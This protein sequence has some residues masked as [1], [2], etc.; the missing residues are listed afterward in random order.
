MDGDTKF[1]PING[2]GAEDYFCGS[3]NFENQKTRQYEIFSTAYTGLH[4]A[5]KPNG[6]YKSTQ[7]AL[8][9]IVSARKRP[10]FTY[11]Y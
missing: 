5:I 3:H 6:L 4:Q 7:N 9:Y 10:L 8:G 1:P 2:T 11:M